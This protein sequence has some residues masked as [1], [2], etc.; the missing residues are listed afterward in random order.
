MRAAAL[1]AGATV[2]ISRAATRDD[3]A[4]AVREALEP[5]IDLA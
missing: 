4:L 5:S 3:L 1:A 2:A